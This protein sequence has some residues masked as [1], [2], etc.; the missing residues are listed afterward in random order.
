MTTKKPLSREEVLGGLG[1]R[2]AKQASTLL[3]LIENRTAR[4][5]AESQQAAARFT[6][7]TTDTE[8]AQSYLTALAQGRDRI[9]Q[10]TIRD[11][12]RYAP[13]WAELVPENPAVR[14]TVAH[15]LGEKYRFTRRV[16]RGIRMAVGLDTPTVQAAYQQQYGQPLSTLYAPRLRPTERIG[17]GW[18]RVA[19]WLENR[20]PFWT[21]YAMTLTNTVGSSVLALP[22]ALAGVGPLAAVVILIVLGLANLLT[23]AYMAEVFTRTGSMRY[24]RGFVGRVVTDYLGSG[25]ALIL[26][27]ATLCYCVLSLC[28]YYIGFS[29]TL[30]AATHL[31][32]WLW[33]GLLFLVGLYLMGRDS[34][35][36][37]VA[38]ALVIG[39]INIGLILIL[40]VLA[41]RW[42][43]PANL[44]YVN[45]PG[46]NGRPFEP[47][48]LRLLLGVV[49]GIYSGQLSVS[50]CARVVLQR[51][52]SGRA[53]LQGATLALF[54]AI[55]LFCIWVVAVNGAVAPG[56][57][58]QETGTALIPLAQKAGPLVHLFGA[59]YVFLAIGM[60]SIHASLGLVNLMREWLPAALLHKGVWGQRWYSLLLLTPMILVFLLAEWLLLTGV[61]SFTQLTSLRGVLMAPL[62]AGI[63]PALLLVA[64]R[65]KGEL[66]PSVVYRWLGWRWLVGGIYGLFLSSI[67]VHGLVLWTN[68][69]QRGLALA[70]GVLLLG[71]TIWVIR[72]GAFTR[73]IVIEIRQTEERPD[74]LHLSVIAA[75]QP[76]AVIA[77]LGYATGEE[78]VATTNGAINPVINAGI[79]R[80]TPLRYVRFAL[81]V[82][83]AGEVKVW[84]HQL[85]R[86][87]ASVGLAGEVILQNADQTIVGR[88]PLVGGQAIFSWRSAACQVEIRLEKTE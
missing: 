17:W 58:V 62:M 80:L 69:L 56:V 73:R 63:F 66:L 32:A 20:P 46:L 68:P 86:V 53:L 70:L 83:A 12:E 31:P 45:L 36:A 30:A 1:G 18:A 74:Q 2:T 34:L 42:V 49:L 11:L 67:F 29:T 4:C 35:N 15:R 82:L 76:Q 85:T 8:R 71:M 47:L 14:A 54:T 79:S 37:T 19:G 27:I 48:I 41:L 60:I 87:G 52:P 24:G 57:L 65:R 23:M 16:T 6:T 61:G 7:A 88:W 78:K 10:P 72:R 50:N 26:S 39:A 81:P 59:I 75:G 5:L 9:Y 64:S 55:L 38:S 51:D 22:I 44:F 3:T 21:A 84:T 43:Q 25:S 33:A 77:H 13:Q 40:S 28:S